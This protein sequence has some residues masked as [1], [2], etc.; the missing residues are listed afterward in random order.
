MGYGRVDERTGYGS[1]SH[2]AQSG[3]GGYTPQ[4]PGQPAPP[5]QSPPPVQEQL[6]G[7]VIELE[8]GESGRAAGTGPRG[9][10]GS[11]A[12]KQTCRCRRRV[13]GDQGSSPRPRPPASFRLTALSTNSLGDR[14][15]SSAASKLTIATSPL[16]TDA[17]A[18]EHPRGTRRSHALILGL[19]WLL[20]RSL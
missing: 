1:R 16:I 2:H 5:P 7:L 19:F 8:A 9:S 12:C 18:C 3:N 6:S 10:R 15:G 4:Y 11:R 13:H 20:A 17:S 14:S